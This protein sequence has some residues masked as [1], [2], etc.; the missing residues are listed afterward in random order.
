ML[1]AEVKLM[2]HCIG[3]GSVDVFLILKSFW[4]F[5]LSELDNLAAN[6]RRLNQGQAPLGAMS[7]KKLHNGEPLKTVEEYSICND[8][9]LFEC[10]EFI[11]AFNV[12]NAVLR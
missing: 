4:C 1:G 12:K 7:E 6:L 11:C 2:L 3:R 9:P 10:I 5:S 8:T